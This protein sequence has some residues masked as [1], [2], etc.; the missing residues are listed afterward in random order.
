LLSG[1]FIWGKLVGSDRKG[2]L[3][4][5]VLLIGGG[6]TG[7][8]LARDL[9]LRGVSCILVERKH[10]N[11]GASGANHG[12]LHSGARYVSTD[13]EVAK[14]CRKEAEILKKFAPQCIED[15]GGFFV[16]VEGDDEKYVADFP[17]LCSRCG[18]RCDAV[19]IEEAR[20]L[21]PCLSGR[22]IAAY[23]V[24]DA[25][26]DP[27]RLSLEN[28]SHARELGTTLLCHTRVRGF[29]KSGRRIQSVQLIDELSGEETILEAREIVNA[30]GAWGAEV[31][32][33]A[34]VSIDMH[35]SKGS[36]LVTN[37]RLT[38]RVI[39]RL[40]PPADGDILV[41]GG[42]VSILG[43]TSVRVESLELIRPTVE[44]V[45]LIV[46]EGAAMLP[47]LETTRY[48]RAYAGV[49]PLISPETE[50]DDRTVS[51]GFTLLDHSLEGLENFVSI[52]GGKLSTYRLMA[53]KTTDLI[54]DRLGVSR[55]CLTRTQ[56]LPSSM[57]S[58][59]TA[60]VAAPRTW[61]KDHDPE[62]LLL[63]EC[64]MVP[65]SV[66]DLLM[67]GLQEQDDPPELNTLSRHSRIG[68]GQCQG[69]FC[70]FRVTAHMHEKGGLT[71][72]LDGL[73]DFL[74]ERWWGER[75][76]LWGNQLIQ[77][78]LK[79]ALYTGLCD[80]DLTL[81]PKREKASRIWLD[82]NP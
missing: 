18:I 16:A 3:K 56:M 64:E 80:L 82:Q 15:T 69:T 5:Q 38:K 14:E 63:C 35:Y 45:D 49:R 34:G 20:E 26:I 65:K 77:A 13:P 62:N 55:P 42:T 6:A 74:R 67:D 1:L 59:W 22:I 32:A 54:C 7:A 29:K 25:S 44:E 68:K 12:L 41:P 39:N 8:G 81:H 2:K 17:Q 72:S 75:A 51:R 19:P 47:S 60:P 33:L 23:F 43:T 31:S 53:E 61:L 40:R 24:E 4:T 46:N 27:F 70:G 76:V 52:P 37:R 78:E 21:E 58:S 71:P 36:L 50:R 28:I 10:I 57:L 73:G 48:I 30:S 11:A 79:E 9:S 66:V